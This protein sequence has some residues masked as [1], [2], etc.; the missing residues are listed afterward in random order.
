[1]QAQGISIRLA[2]TQTPPSV[3][4][5]ETS[6]SG[7]YRIENIPPGNYTLTASAPLF[8]TETIKVTILPSQVTV[9]NIRLGFSVVRQRVE[10]HA[11]AP[12]T[13]AQNVAPPARLTAKQVV[14]APLA[15]QKTQET[16]PLIAGVIRTPNGRTYIGGLAESMGM[17]T[18][19]N[20][21]A[22]DPVTGAFIIDLPVD[23]INTLEVNET[24]LFAEE[25]GFVGGL[26]SVS[27]K[28][29]GSDW[30][31]KFSDIFPH[32]LAENGQL[33]G[34]KSFEP[35]AYLTGPL[36]KGKLNFSEAVTYED[37]RENVRGLAW[38][39]NITTTTGLNSYTTFQALLSERHILT[40]HFQIFPER[41]ANANIDALIPKPASENY[42]QRGFS[43]MLSD[44]LTLASGTSFVTMFHLLGV[45][46]YVHGQGQS[47]MLVTP[48]GYSGSYFNDWSRLS[49]QQEGG[50]TIELPEKRWHGRHRL[51]LG[52]NAGRRAYTG[53]DI[54]RPIQILGENNSLL[55]R[56]DFTGGSTLRA[57][58]TEVSGFVSDQWT[59]NT[60]L[61]V[62]LGFR[63]T[64][65]AIGRDFAPAPRLGIVFTPD[66][67][68]KTIFRASAGIFYDR[69]PLLAA[70]FASN[71]E[72]VITDLVPG[73]LPV[74]SPVSYPN[75]CAEAAAGGIRLL[76]SCSEFST[77]PYSTIWRAELEQ[78]ITRRIRARAGYLKSTTYNIFVTSPATLPTLGTA[79]LLQNTGS[80]RYHAL[81]F[82]VVY[83]PNARDR[84]T[85][86]YVHSQSLGDLNTLSE[87]FGAFWQPVIHPNEFANL[88]SDVP[89]RFT[90]LS[91]LAVPFK[92]TF[93]PA[94][95]IHSGFPY[96]I[97]DQ[98]QRYV[99]TPD[100]ARFPTYFTFDFSLYR[101][102]HAPIFKGRKVR[103]GFFSI[104]TTDRRNPTAVYNNQVSPYAGDFAGPQKRVD[105]FIFDIR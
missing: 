61:A 18:I 48:V 92:L 45:H 79:M 68:G 23:A 100:Q 20:A 62:N 66:K 103:V 43:T 27:T 29:P 93:I 80:A 3:F 90:M 47:D 36:V 55:E 52:A 8:Q 31:F 85:A 101:D 34:A 40:G 71:P 35:R 67:Q 5:V 88:P 89:D 99:G 91:S 10:V 59:L 95:D 28:A 74:G 38:P 53:T 11:S 104:N 83:Q 75:R 37:N 86:T 39:N 63:A 98:F 42:G 17:F 73:N 7:F 24:P 60:R 9:R 94:F 54:S 16:L 82:A 50:E 41:Q 87:L 15:E 12:L 32:I 81:E 49:D 78:Q 56:I 77:T 69:F 105:G 44:R 57:S 21:E 102:F 65:Q 51:I 64:T 6:E 22:V 96:S 14:N 26:T 30:K 97:V 46:N 19:D 58:A 84:I 2:G 1:M 72:R 25:G 70:D 4:K 76:S 33:V 13:G